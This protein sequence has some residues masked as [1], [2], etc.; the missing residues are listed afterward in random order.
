M[1]LEEY[2]AACTY[3]GE[4]CNYDG[5]YWCERKNDGRYASDSK[6]SSFCEAY[7]RSNSTRENM[8]DNSLS[9]QSSPCYITTIICKLLEMNDNCYHL[10]KLRELRDRMQDNT[11]DL[12]LLLMYDQIGP[13]ISKCLEE[14]KENGLKFA[15]KAFN[16][17]IDPAVREIEAGNDKIAKDIYYIMTKRFAKYYGIENHKQFSL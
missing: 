8:C 12:P 9:H 14:D 6:C 4:T 7:G 1:A 15:E 13:Q 5:K 2:C 17:Y 11:F 10:K 3:L 16:N